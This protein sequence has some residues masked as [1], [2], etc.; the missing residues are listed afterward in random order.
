M[1]CCSHCGGCGC[2]Q[3]RPNPFSCNNPCGVT[4]SNTAACESL[5]SQI[6]NFT[7]QFFGT[8]VKTEIDGAVTWSLP[9]D[10]EIGLE[11]NPRGEGEGLAC[12]FLR[13]FREGITGLTG[14]DG[15]TGDSGTDG[16]NAYT[17]SLASFTQPTPGFP[18]VV[19]QSAYNPA[20]MVGLEVFIQTSG[21][22]LVDAAGTDGVLYLTLTQGLSGASGSITAGKLIVPTGPPGR[23]IT[24][25]QG[26]QGLTGPQGND[27]TN[28]TVT[29]DQF[30]E[31]AGTDY[32][33]TVSFAILDFTTAVMQMILPNEGRYLLTVSVSL[34]GLAGAAATDQVAIRLRD[35]T[36]AALIAGAEHYVTGLTV[37][38]DAMISFCVL[39]ETDSPNHVVS[40]NGKCTSGAVISA[41]ALNSVFTYVQLE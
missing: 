39:H 40:V 14:P 35:A 19:V 15:L 12:Y 27:A 31:A 25:P 18:S 29:N 23:S 10:L 5:P 26:V 33:L 38:S 17:V 32:N 41:L 37:G 8:V 30:F 34:R 1:S 11:N 16:N 7:I 13:L 24:G 6:Q 9:C 22:Y 28:F 4:I 36:D 21:W 20:I 3:C 2:N